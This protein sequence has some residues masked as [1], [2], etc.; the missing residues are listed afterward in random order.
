MSHGDKITDN[1]STRPHQLVPSSPSLPILSP[2]V[3]PEPKD[4]RG[5]VWTVQGVDQ[6]P[7]RDWDGDLAVITGEF[8]PDSDERQ[9]RVLSWG[10]VNCAAFTSACVD[11]SKPRCLPISFPASHNPRS[12]PAL[13]HHHQHLQHSCLSGKTL[14]STAAFSR[15]A[16]PPPPSINIRRSISC[17]PSTLVASLA[18]LLIRHPHS[19]VLHTNIALL[20]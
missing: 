12:Q 17:Q 2:Q 1:S 19:P 4:S 11:L 13:R 15:L 10:R 14:P 5:R 3:H 8:L 9:I 6:R 20:R 18:V 16:S 7:A